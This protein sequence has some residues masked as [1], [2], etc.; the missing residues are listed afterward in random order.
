MRT[1]VMA[2]IVMAAA[3]PALAWGPEGHTVIARVATADLNSQ[4]TTDLHWIVSIGVPALN[5]LIDQKYPKKCQIDPNDPWGP[6]PD[7]RTDHDQH[8]NLANWA[9]CFRYLDRSTAGWHFDDI[10][11]GASPA[12]K[13]AV[14]NPDWCKPQDGCVSRAFADN[15]RKL[16][17]PD[18]TDPA[19]VAMALAYVV[20]FL[21]DMHQP[22]HVEDNN[23]DLGGN[24]VAITTEGSGVSGTE[25]HGLWDTP[26]VE[27]ALGANLDTATARVTSDVEHADP[28]WTAATKTVDDVI[29]STDGWVED[30][31][32]KAQT[33]YSLLHIAVGAGTVSGVV[34]DQ[35]YVRTESGVVRTQIDEAAVRLR[36]ALNASLTW[37]PPLSH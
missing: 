18:L 6:V 30:A 37:S 32:G 35:D 36:A 5:R 25:L 3:T 17:A 11:L 9:D 4:A 20:H 19:S 24:D 12:G 1:A 10:P 26:L 7:Y 27:K 22:L 28:S 2:T 29:A 31:H 23:H 13:L 8:T 33:A 15:L 14:P 34:V 16:A 21:G